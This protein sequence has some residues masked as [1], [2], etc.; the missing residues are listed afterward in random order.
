MEVS[1]RYFIDSSIKMAELVYKQL[2]I[3]STFQGIGEHHFVEPKFKWL[4]NVNSLRT[5]PEYQRW[6]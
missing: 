5:E 3:V 4:K 6:T 2:T 1:W